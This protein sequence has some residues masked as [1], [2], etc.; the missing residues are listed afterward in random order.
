MITHSNIQLRK[1]AF[2]IKNSTTIVLSEW[3]STLGELGLSERMMPR[4]VSTC[5]NSTYDMLEFAI[6]YHDA[7]NSV[8]SNRSM[9]MR[10]LELSNSEWKILTELRDSLKVSFVR[11]QSSGSL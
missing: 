4:D 8:T 1:I 5:W 2:T 3:Y 10:P 9:K 6:P 7:I 11:S